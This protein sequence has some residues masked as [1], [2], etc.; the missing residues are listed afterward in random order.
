MEQ[1]KG[2][3]KPINRH[4]MKERAAER[5]SQAAEKADKSE[6][7][8]L[9]QV[10]A[11]PDDAFVIRL[12]L[13]VIA[14]R[15]ERALFD[16]AGDL[17]E[18]CQTCALL[19]VADG[20]MQSFHSDLSVKDGL[21]LKLSLTAISP[22]GYYPDTKEIPAENPHPE[23]EELDYDNA[24]EETAEPEKF[25][26][27]PAEDSGADPAEVS[28]KL[29]LDPVLSI[30]GKNNQTVIDQIDVDTGEIIPEEPN[31]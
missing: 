26:E 1:E 30:I 7:V 15:S 19:A 4:P 28:Y 24:I 25:K 12:V 10:D 3:I 9:D 20:L 8:S 6:E 18:G 21:M 29:Q 16:E 5:V 2:V 11:D 14:G 13:D 22:C 31:E 17:K 27:I 23:G